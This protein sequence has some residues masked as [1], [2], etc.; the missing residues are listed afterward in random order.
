[1]GDDNSL[2]AV[3]LWSSVTDGRVRGRPGALFSVTR[4]GSSGL[5]VGGGSGF[6]MALRIRVS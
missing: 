2:T 4:R 3:W 1:M 5:W 6:L